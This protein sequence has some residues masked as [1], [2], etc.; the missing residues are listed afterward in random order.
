MSPFALCAHRYDQFGNMMLILFAG[1]D[2]TAHTMTW[3]TFEMARKPAL[4]ARLQAEVDAFFAKLGGRDMEYADLDELPFMTRCVMETLRLA[5]LAEAR[6][7]DG[8]VLRTLH[9]E[10][11]HVAHARC[12]DAVASAARLAAATLG[13]TWCRR[14]LWRVAQRGLHVRATCMLELL[15]TE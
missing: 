6:E 3:L 5:R 9:G 14:A 15:D 4:Q 7:G 11:T 10:H 8:N 12:G 2:T 1:H 13:R